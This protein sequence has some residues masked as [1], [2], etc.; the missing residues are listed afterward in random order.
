M[1][2]Q[3]Q[4]THT[5]DPIE[6]FTL[7]LEE[8]RRDSVV[9]GPMRLVHN[10]F[11]DFFMGFFRLLA[12]LAE[13][14]RNG[15]LPEWVP[16]AAAEPRAWPADLR[17][18]ESGWAEDRGLYDPWGD[19][20]V[21]ARCERAETNAEP[22]CEMPGVEQPAGPPRRRGRA[23]KCGK[24]SGLALVRPRHAG[25]CAWPLW[26]GP[27]LLWREVAG[28]LRFDSKKPVLGGGQI[29]VEIVSI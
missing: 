29:C 18:R 19:S 21:H 2:T 5:Q 27:G 23:R 24:E 28:F 6:R 17:P 8:I 15:T 11:L 20:A 12:S 10:L 4:D 13:Q 9:R 1:T 14:R 25:D 26:R 7:R 16:A 3:A 22:S